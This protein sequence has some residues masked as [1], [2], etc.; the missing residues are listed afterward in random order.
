MSE[1]IDI[2]EWLGYQ[3]KDGNKFNLNI[4]NYGDETKIYCVLYKCSLEE[5]GTIKDAT[6]ELLDAKCYHSEQ[7]TELF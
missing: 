3:D 2:D 6:A 4:H 7:L 1:E 5:D